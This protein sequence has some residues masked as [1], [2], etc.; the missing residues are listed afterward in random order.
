MIY[1]LAAIAAALALV[2][3]VRRVKKAAAEPADDFTWSATEHRR[4]DDSTLTS[5]QIE[6][7][8]AAAQKGAK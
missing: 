8:E 3:G 7:A 4:W 1:V 6:A 2:F 5:E